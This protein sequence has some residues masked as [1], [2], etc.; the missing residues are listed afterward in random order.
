MPAK[1]KFS[2][3]AGFFAFRKKIKDCSVDCRRPER[4]A[5]LAEENENAG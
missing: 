2:K 1:N 3:W 5:R 4:G